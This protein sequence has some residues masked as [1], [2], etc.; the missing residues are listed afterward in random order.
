MAEQNYQTYR[1][2]RLSDMGDS[3]EAAP[4]D[5][6][7]DE[8]VAETQDPPPATE[9][10]TEATNE[11]EAK[12]E[13]PQ[14]RRNDRV[15]KRFRRLSGQLRDKDTQI[16]E[17][18][19]QVDT[20]TKLVQP[21]QD[22]SPQTSDTSGRPSR[23]NF[24]DDDDYFEALADWKASE[25]V[26]AALSRRDQ[27]ERERQEAEKASGVSETYAGRLQEA[28]TRYDDYDEVVESSDL[29]I[30]DDVTGAILESEQGPDIVYY[31]AQNPEEGKRL[32]GLSAV[33][34]GKELGKIEA[35]VAWVPDDDGDGNEE[36]PD[37]P[38]QRQQRQRS[39]PISPISSGG[40]TDTQPQD[41]EKLSYRDY[42][43]RRLAGKV[44]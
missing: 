38:P 44:R 15:E 23:G 10:Q 35:K 32:N 17:L 1:T 11:D 31:L 40:S 13:E 3:R 24:D 19:G 22:D 14:S 7:V 26:A 29:I 4:E 9:A 36:E 28:R 16:A 6:P 27:E 20:L 12:E 5:S 33:K 39:R 43:A 25:R 21:K 18:K 8:P 37:T 2:Q 42:R 34:L 30:S 41:T